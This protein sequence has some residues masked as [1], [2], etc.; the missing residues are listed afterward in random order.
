MKRA[1][2][3][4]LAFWLL[5]SCAAVAQA[6]SAPGSSRRPHDLAGFLRERFHADARPA[7]QLARPTT[8]PASVPDQAMQTGFGPGQV[9]QL[10][11]SG[12]DEPEEFEIQAPAPMQNPPDVPELPPPTVMPSGPE[13]RR[14]EQQTQGEEPM[15]I[16]CPPQ[17]DWRPWWHRLEFLVLTT[18]N[19]RLPQPIAFSDTTGLI[20]TYFGSEDMSYGNYPGVRYTLGKWL[21]RQHRWGL[22]GGF[23]ATASYGVSS[24]LISSNNALSVFGQTLPLVR[25]YVDPTTNTVQYMDYGTEFVGEQSQIGV[26]DIEADSRIWGAGFNVLHPLWQKNNKQVTLLL[27]ARFLQLRENLAVYTNVNPQTTNQ[28]FFQGNAVDTGTVVTVNDFISA[29]NRFG[30]FNLAARFEC[31]WDTLFVN[32]QTGVAVGS[33]RQEIVLSGGSN[34]NGVAVDGGFLVQPT[35]AGTRVKNELGFIPEVNLTIGVKCGSHCR[36]FGGY[37]LL[38]WDVARPG[39]QID[40]RINLDRIPVQVGDSTYTPNAGPA[41]PTSLFVSDLIW[42]QGLHMGLEFTY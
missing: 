37:D 7:R 27:G 10:P 34:S 5:A 40:D 22:E 30:G 23:F 42:I 4:A 39:R 17:P 33:T 25:P 29:S 8:L 18:S 36:F 31:E 26:M 11:S 38:L 21:D 19:D 1:K 3:L 13:P 12:F 16:P 20:A 9:Q 14:P 24:F 35:N 15:F 2:L 6:P 41:F 28:V 32:L